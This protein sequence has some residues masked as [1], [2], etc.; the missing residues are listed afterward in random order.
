MKKILGLDLGTNSIGWALVNEAENDSEKSSIIKLGVRVNPLSVDEK[1]NFESGKSITT[2]ADRTLKRSMR[3]NL[4]RYKLRRQNL[5]SILKHAGWITDDT[6]LAE[7]GNFTTFQTL[8]L[9]AKAVDSEI[10]LT[11]L[12]RVLLMINKKRGYKSSRKLKNDEDGQAV[13]SMGVAKELYDEQIT[14]GEYVYRN[15]EVYKYNIPDFY[16]SDLENEFDRIWEFQKAFY[17][18]ILNDALKED[19]KGKTKSQTWTI[20]KEPFGI[21]GIKRPSG[22]DLIKQ[23]YSLRHMA[24]CESLDLESLAIVL[25][26]INGQI[27][28]SSGYLGSISDRSKELYF[29]H[30]TVGQFLVSRLEKN[31]NGSL[32][33]LVFYRQDYMDEFER[34]WNTQRGFHPELTDEL[35]SEIRDVVI[36]YQRRLKS[37]KALVSVCE[38][39]GRKQEMTVNGKLKTRIVGP[40]VCPKSSPLFQEFQIWQTIN[41]LKINGLSL[42]LEEKELLAEELSVKDRLS[43][44]E[45]LKL[46]PGRCKTDDVNFK[47]IKGNRTQS[48]LYKAYAKIIEQSGHGQYDFS[49]MPSSD[50]ER[51]VREIFGGLGYDTDILEFNSDADLE[52]QPLYRLWHLLYSYEGDNSKT[53]NGKLVSWISANL[54]FEPEYAKYIANV[55][56]E[57][58]YGNLSARA[59]R[60]ILPFMKKGA[61]YSDACTEAGYRHSEKSLTKEEIAGKSYKDRLPEISKNSLRNPVVEKILNQMVN[62]VNQVIEK[63]GK[64]DEVRIELARELKKSQ[65]ERQNAAAAISKSKTKNEECL[66]EL[67]E[68]FNIAHPSRNDI[69]RYKLY[70]ELALNGYKTLYSGTYISQEKLFSKEFDIEHIIPQSRLFDDSFSNKTLE[71]RQVNI[72][73][74]NMTACDFVRKTYGADAFSEYQANVDRLYYKEGILSK[75]KRDKLLM[76]ET[77]I[78]DNFIER[79]LRDTQYISKKAKEMLEEVFASVVTTTG[80]ITDRLREDWQLVDVMKE[81]N[82][83]KYAMQGLV[84]SYMDKDGKE[85][86]KIKDWTKRNDHRH[87]AMDALTIAFTKRSFIQYLNNLNAR[88]PKNQDCGNI[89]DLSRYSS[90]DIPKSDRTKVVGYIESTQLYRDNKGRLRFIPPIPLDEFRREAKRHLDAVLV[91]VK[92]KNKVVTRNVNSI[93]RKNG[94]IREVQL[95]P[96]GQLHNETVYGSILKYSSKEEKIG[97]GF[98][99]AKIHSVASPV[100]REALLKRLAEFGND[101]KK[102]FSGKNSLDK[103]P[104]YIDDLHTSTV[105]LKVKTLSMETQYTIRKEISPLNFKD[106]K[107]INKVIDSGIRTLLLERLS[108]YGGNPQKAFSNLDENPIWVNKEKGLQ[109]KRVTVSGVNNAVALHD[110]HDYA[111]RTIVDENKVPVPADFVSTSNNHHVAVFIDGDGNLQEHIVSFLEAVEAARTG[112]PVVNRDYK[113]DEG[114]KF[115]FTMKQNEYFVFPN[116]GNGFDPAEVDLKDPE[117][118]NIISPNLFRVQKLATKNYVFRHHL[119]TNVN[120]VKELR[121]ITWK[122]IQNVNGLKGIIKVR[123]NHLG[124]IVGEG[125]Y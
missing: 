42:G 79:D 98:D 85:I 40:K 12:A 25:Q 68:K 74:G 34:I 90:F 122:R 80:A 51:I 54:G 59:M 26:E 10:S 29:N 2:N 6:V 38:L 17:P 35:K 104:V 13:D 64:P 72:Q 36:F 58:D 43:K 83:D 124:Q 120:E 4:Q 110:R 62:V 82:W 116:V 106:E 44:A 3:R 11:E 87:H 32:K 114:W 49:K 23:N 102:A 69:I 63:F 101:S 93:K 81:L 31:P 30:Q 105:P 52:Q 19:V 95:T 60:K 78:P 99:I 117:N 45:I 61:V 86:R 9:R 55:T 39:E 7:T 107:A 15:I 56:F 28:N 118:Y 84:E 47:E 66:T 22:R 108:E 100:Y 113:K 24:L 71:S 46:L 96:R 91:S 97:A 119:E 92:A 16:R 111:G 65:K 123:V 18:D 73:K 76:G 14:P 109:V 77:E 89:V 1:N 53:G 20:C 112:N 41:N 94:V 70:N 88:V 48:A 27:M 8:R 37:Q 5:L 103:N 67:Q 57:P 115:L 75:S 125:E 121:D 21:E 33:N 50:A